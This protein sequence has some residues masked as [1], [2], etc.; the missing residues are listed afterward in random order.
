[1]HAAFAVIA[2]VQL[3][4]RRLIAARKRLLRAA[5]FHQTRN[6]EFEV[7]ASAQLAGR[8]IGARTEIAARPQAANRHAT[9]WVPCSAWWQI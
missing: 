3:G 6:R 7:L 9:A 1:M 2:Q 8:I 4:K 5:L